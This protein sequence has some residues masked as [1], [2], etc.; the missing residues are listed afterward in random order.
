MTQLRLMI[1]YE[2]PDSIDLKPYLDEDLI[3]LGSQ[4]E[5]WTYKLHGVLVHQGSISNGHYYAMTVKPYAK[6]YLVKV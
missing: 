4:N 6:G 1:S 2:F 3:L 5:N